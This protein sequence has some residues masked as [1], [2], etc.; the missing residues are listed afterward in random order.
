MK[1]ASHSLDEHGQAVDDEPQV[2]RRR[3]D[4]SAASTPSV[5]TSDSPKVATASLSSKA[6]LFSRPKL[7]LPGPQPEPSP[8]Y[9]TLSQEISTPVQIPPRP[10]LVVLDLNNTLLERHPHH[11]MSNRH[12]LYR[13]YLTTFLDYIFS[14]RSD[15]GQKRFH[16]CVWSSSKISN[17]FRMV[18]DLGLHYMPP[19]VEQQ[20][21][22]KRKQQRRMLYAVEGREL[23]N[24]P[25]DLFDRRVETFKNL[26][27]LFAKLE[28]DGKGP[29]TAADT[30]C[31]DDSL[32]KYVRP[33]SR[34][35]K[36]ALMQVS[37]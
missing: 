31:L 32:T 26:D 7:P 12:V 36:A 34:C 20:K 27:L 28:K 18:Q 21:G 4:G 5:P 10:K 9:L 11:K 25:D 22:V 24:L 29:W 2:K 13:P 35:C 33:L 19:H 1:R 6:G 23:M 37:V 30:I 15:T 17:V 8:A 3:G 14:K 16:V